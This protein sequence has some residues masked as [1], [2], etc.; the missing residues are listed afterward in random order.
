LRVA[1]W[2][3]RA[4]P[5][6]DPQS[7]IR[8]PQYPQQQYL[9]LCALSVF[10]VNVSLAAD[11]SGGASSGDDNSVVIGRARTTTHGLPWP[12][13]DPAVIAQMKAALVA[14]LDGSFVILNVGPWVLATDLD[15]ASARNFATSTISRY[16]A[17]IQRQLF[18]KEARSAP[19]KV[20]LFKDKA[21]YETWNLKLFNEKPSTPYGYYS[22]G[23]NALVMNIGTGGGTLLHEMTHAMAE[24]DFPG[25]P[26]WLNEGLGSLFE[27]SSITPSG[28]ISGITNW[29]LAGLQQDLPR[30]NSPRLATL[31]QMDDTVFYGPHSGSNYAAARYLMQWLQAQGKLEAFYVRVRERRD[32]DAL[33]SLCAVIDDQATVAQLEHQFYAW[34]KTLN[35]P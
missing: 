28:H 30:G 34:V 19:V 20:Y 27:A 25:I 4:T 35:Q 23:R 5:Q 15:A 7:A 9:L 16:A 11:P 26:A 3:F 2:N 29:R 33:A 12:E 6:A 10:V 22:R 21:S 17:S 14:E 31:L 24:V 13:P 18:T 1:D 8:N 32:A